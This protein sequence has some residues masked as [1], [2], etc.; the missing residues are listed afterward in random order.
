M[1]HRFN[2]NRH[3]SNTQLLQNFLAAC[4]R[5]ETNPNYQPDVSNEKL[6]SLVMN[7]NGTAKHSPR[8]RA[9]AIQRS[10]IDTELGMVY[11]I[12][13]A[14]KA[15]PEGTDEFPQWHIDDSIV[16]LVE[17][18]KGEMSLHN[19]EHAGNGNFN[20]PLSGVAE[21][22]LNYECLHEKQVIEVKAIVNNF[23]M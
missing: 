18:Q 4:E 14:L 10:P 9:I 20:Q 5:I 21:Q 6:M 16:L 23:K 3:I 12:K 22:F 19:R 8:K 11:Q 1:Q 15:V 13:L 2:Y 7:A 17:R